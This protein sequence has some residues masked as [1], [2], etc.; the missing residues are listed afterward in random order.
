MFNIYPKVSNKQRG[1]LLCN[2]KLYIYTCKSNI[3]WENGLMAFG[4]C[5]TRTISNINVWH[6]LFPPFLSLTTDHDNRFVFRI[7]F[8]NMTLFLAW[9]IVSH[10]FFRQNQ[11]IFCIKITWSST[12]VNRILSVFHCYANDRIMFT[13]DSK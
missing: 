13:P 9:F 10:L 7:M 11:F 8:L 2:S 4:F 6:S 3:G 5:P 12:F 1:L